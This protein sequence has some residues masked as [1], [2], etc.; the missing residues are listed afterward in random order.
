MLRE[1]VSN[2]WFTILLVI[3][4]GL[5][6]YTKLAFASRFSNFLTLVGNSKYLKIYSRDQKFIDVFDGILFVNLIISIALFVMIIVRHQSNNFQIDINLF[7]K[8]IFGLGVIFLIKV[9]V[10]RL[11]GS[12]YEIDT[13]I[14]RYLFQKISY[15]NFLGLVL[16]PV[17]M[18]LLY[19]INPSKYVVYSIVFL[20][21]V[22]NIIGILTTIKNHQKLLLN[23]LFYFI[24]YLCA[25][26]ISP[27]I[28]LYKLTIQ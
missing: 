16:I 21:V 2:E 15:R 8:L 17:N 10:E 6:A 18:L 22:I 7:L 5:I 4:I 14:D 23:N 9:L 25:L 27:Y 24:L 19:T 11:I 3:S 12:L 28:I 1:I 13:L 26:E 20:L